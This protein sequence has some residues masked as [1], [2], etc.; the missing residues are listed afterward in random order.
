M[1]VRLDGGLII[2]EGQCG[3]ADAPAL[4]SL[5]TVSDGRPVDVSRALTVHAAV[6]QVLM[7]R[8]PCLHGKASDP[9]LARWL[10]QEAPQGAPW[11]R[12]PDVAG[13]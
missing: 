4:L 9:L 3:L 7:A 10:L 1:S 13:L 8:Q 5:L 2:L 12:Q 6:W 11:P